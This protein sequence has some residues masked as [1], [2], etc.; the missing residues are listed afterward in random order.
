[1]T[2]GFFCETMGQMLWVY[3]LPV[4]E[5][6]TMVS[7]VEPGYLTRWQAPRID[8]GNGSSLWGTRCGYTS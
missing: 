5:D 4:N 2:L 6:P 3:L 1:M 8:L 7:E